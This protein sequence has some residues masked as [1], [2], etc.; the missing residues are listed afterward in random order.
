VTSKHTAA[1]RNRSPH[2][3]WIASYIERFEYDGEDRRNLNRRCLA[4]ENTILVKARNRDE[5]WEKAMAHGRLSEGSEARLGTPRRRGTWHFEGLTRLL[6]VYERLADGAEILWVE[7]AGRSVR[8]IRAL[9]K[10]KRDLDA[11]E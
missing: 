3:W 6:P 1:H 11:F 2:G 8:S 9:I 7:H 4:W 5:A 10:K